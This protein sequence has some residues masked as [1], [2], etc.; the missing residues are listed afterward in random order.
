MYDEKVAVP[1]VPR[2]APLRDRVNMLEDT[3][4]SVLSR[5][6]RLENRMENDVLGPEPEQERGR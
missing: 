1:R 3:L 5:L 2:N 4:D 6:N